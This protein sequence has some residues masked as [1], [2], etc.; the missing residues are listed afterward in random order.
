MQNYLLCGNRLNSS[1]RKIN[2]F[3]A[4][5]SRLLQEHFLLSAMMLCAQVRIKGILFALITA[6]GWMS[7]EAGIYVLLSG[8]ANAPFF[9]PSGADRL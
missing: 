7:K 4:K 3:T 8:I 6:L 9:S 1:L 2:L 5:F